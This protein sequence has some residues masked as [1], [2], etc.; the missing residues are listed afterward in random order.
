MLVFLESKLMK[1]QFYLYSGRERERERKL[2]YSTEC[3][4]R[5]FS[6]FRTLSS[7]IECSFVFCVSFFG[8]W[9]SGL[10]N[11]LLSTSVCAKIMNEKSNQLIYWGRDVS[12]FSVYVFASEFAVLLK[13]WMAAIMNN[14]GCCWDFVILHAIETLRIYVYI[15]Y[16]TT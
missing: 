10:P 6:F 11:T 15:V 16:V 1:I 14:F 12:L 4:C 13:Q 7:L 8:H 9:I 5:A 2:T 3:C